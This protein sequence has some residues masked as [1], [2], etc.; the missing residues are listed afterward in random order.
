MRY[1]HDRDFPPQRKSDLLF[2]FRGMAM[3]TNLVSAKVFIHFG[4]Q[5]FDCSLPPGPRGS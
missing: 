2:N 3:I 5:L 4:K 1:E